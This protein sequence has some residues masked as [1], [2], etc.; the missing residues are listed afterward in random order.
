MHKRY[1]NSVEKVHLQTIDEGKTSDMNL[2]Y[3]DD[4]SLNDRDSYTFGAIK[5]NLRSSSNNKLQ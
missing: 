4:Q 1:S 2:L 3:M 5:K